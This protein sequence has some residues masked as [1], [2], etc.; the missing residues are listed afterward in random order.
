[1]EFWNGA[2]L[3]GAL[4]LLIS[5]VASDISSRMGAPL[6][7][8]FLAFGMLAGEDGPGG[9]RFDDF[10][11]AYVI[12]TL[13]LAV[14]IFDGG[15]RTR[16]ETFRV[17][18]WPA[19]SLA[20]FGVVITAAL[21]GLCASWALGLHWLQGMLL[22]AIVGSTDA[23]AVFALLRTQGANLQERVGSTLEIESGS[24]DPMAI[25]LSVALLEL[26]AAGR[27]ELEL[28][29]LSA[30]AMQ[31][32]IG[33]AL[34][35]GGGRLLVWLINRLRLMT[36][37]YPLLAVA[38]GLLIFSV[39]AQLGGSGFLAIYLAGLVLGNS[40]L[41]AAQNILRVHDGLA[42]LSQ[43]TMFLILGL[44]I[45]PSQ[46]VDVTLPA[47][48][49]AAFLMLVARP[50]A[51]LVSLLPFQFPWREQ[52]YIGW[53]GLRGAVPI[54]L[55]LFPAM[56]GV[57]DARLYFNVAFFIVLV[58]LLL[59]GWTIA[60]AA[61]L[62][63]LEVPPSAE[64]LQRVTLDMPG[65][66]EHEILGYQVQPGSLIAARDLATL[67]L[68]PGMQ[69]MAVM[70]DGKPQPLGRELRFAPGDFVYVLAQPEALPEV[71]R[72][73]DPHQAPERL[74]EHRYFGDFVLNGD[75][76]LDELADVYGLEIPA[77]AAGKTLAAYLDQLFHGR[78]VVGDRAS[79]GSA[80]LVVREMQAGRVSRVGLKLR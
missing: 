12:G 60:P 61:R 36:G 48:G 17:A 29:V 35:L 16:R 3:V 55:A 40:R 52:L 41:Q 24:N 72:L 21:V 4:L 22:G 75:A 69:V 54:V 50:V 62:L 28:S 33:A 18:L 14:I 66:F 2:I 9:I 67:E 45:T 11:T 73:F 19:L 68:P 53:V 7:L 57:E 74:E 34:G 8:V 49:I 1:V 80:L 20:T 32:A 39:T 42:W 76:L 79:L 25:F 13:A 77:S 51:V 31:F 64:P 37:L 63:R 46:L 5:I 6:L 27:T 15:M 43:I 10:D 78:V 44:L 59:Q 47:L 23:A 65:H 70:R 26:L 56:Y 58:S 38:G 30:F 71:N